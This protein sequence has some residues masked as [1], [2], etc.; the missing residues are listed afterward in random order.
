MKPSKE[1]IDKVKAENDEV[2]SFDQGRFTFLV[3]RPVPAS[4]YSVQGAE[5][6]KRPVVMANMARTMILWPDQENYESIA[7]RYPVIPT[8]IA[9][10]GIELAS[11]EEDAEAKKV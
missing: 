8:A 11:A 2:Y 10:F 6:S 4:V 1:A 7:M 3:K 9:A 5:L